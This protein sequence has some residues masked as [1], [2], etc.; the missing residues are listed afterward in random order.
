MDLTERDYGADFR[1]DRVGKRIIYRWISRGF[2]LDGHVRWLN[3]TN[4][5]RFPYTAKLP[6]PEGEKVAMATDELIA[7]LD[8][9]MNH[10]YSFSYASV[11]F[12]D[13][14]D[15]FHYMLFWV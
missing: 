2:F 14:L 13:D 12:E 6:I 1:E 5:A 10:D 8:E 7:W 4:E 9:N 15:R 3:Q 11:I